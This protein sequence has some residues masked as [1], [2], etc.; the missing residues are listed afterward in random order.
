MPAASTYRWRVP[1]SSTS[2][3]PSS[4]SAASRLWA[5]NGVLSRDSA[6]GVDSYSF[7]TDAEGRFGVRALVVGNHPLV[8]GAEAA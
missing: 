2:Q 6:S 1:A 7:Y 8:I 5:T 3:A 4:T